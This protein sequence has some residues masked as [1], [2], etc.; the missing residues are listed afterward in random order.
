MTAN[1]A[2]AAAIVFHPSNVPYQSGA[3][4][5]LFPNQDAVKRAVVLEIVV[6]SQVVAV[7][8]VYPAP[9]AAVANAPA[10]ALAPAVQRY[11]RV[12]VVQS[13]VGMLAVYVANIFFL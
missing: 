1:H 3:V 12:A 4:V 13:P 2:V 10:V 6:S 7:F 8:S 5:A 9:L 11:V